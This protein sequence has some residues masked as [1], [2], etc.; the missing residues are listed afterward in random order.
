MPERGSFLYSLILHVAVVLAFVFGLP[1]LFEAKIPDEEPIAVQLV[2]LAPE[3]HATQVNPAPPV[4]QAKPE[5]AQNEPPKPEPPKPEPPTPEPPKPEPPKP[6]PPKPAPPAPPPP[7]PPVEKP[8]PPK[9]PP[10]PP[11]PPA[12]KPP[13]PSQAKKP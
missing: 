13:V 3:T 9:P 4:P 10:P 7:P 2:N 8:Q 1:T 5:L 12:P 6:E 11:P